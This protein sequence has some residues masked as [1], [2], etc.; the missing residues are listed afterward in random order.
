MK[1]ITILV[2]LVAAVQIIGFQSRVLTQTE[3]AETYL[4]N[5]CDSIS[6]T[7]ISLTILQ[8]TKQIKTTGRNVTFVRD[9]K[10]LRL[11]VEF[12]MVLT[13]CPLVNDIAGKSSDRLMTNFVFGFI[14]LTYYLVKIYRNGAIKG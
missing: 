2:L 6:W 14:A 4:Y 10:I 9:T 11:V 7:V 12:F 5:L 8:L 1:R 3:A 13:I